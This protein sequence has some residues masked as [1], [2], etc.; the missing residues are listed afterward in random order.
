MVFFAGNKTGVPGLQVLRSE[1]RRAEHIGVTPEFLL[2]LIENALWLFLG[3]NISSY[4][5]A[6]YL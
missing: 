3:R 6:G 2:A 1:H 4:C 5:Q